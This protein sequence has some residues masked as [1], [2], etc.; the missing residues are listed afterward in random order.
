MTL[1]SYLS[2]MFLATILCWGSFLLVIN[3]IN[4]ETTNWIGLFLFYLSLF[5]SLTGTISV[6]G[7]LVRFIFLKHE[8]V[9]DSVSAAFRQ[10]FLISIF[11]VISLILLAYDLLNWLNI[12]FLIIG[13]S[14][15]EYFLLFYKEGRSRKSAP[16]ELDESD[17]AYNTNSL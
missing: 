1:K 4:P 15:I 14:V 2:I 12:L 17:N 7:F 13:L 16:K 3:A 10:S 11:V 9:W 6:I 5:L 8:L